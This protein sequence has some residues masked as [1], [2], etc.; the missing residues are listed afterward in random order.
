M[1][2]T[3]HGIEVGKKGLMA[4]NT[5][6]QT[7]GHNLANIETEGYSRQRVHLKTFIPIYEPTANRVEV[8]GQIGTGVVV[9]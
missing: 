8:P 3:F 4:N 7:I 2:S 9:E 5:A 6:I 1:F